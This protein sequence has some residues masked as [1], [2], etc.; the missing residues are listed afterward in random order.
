MALLWACILGII[1][2][3]IFLAIFEKEIF[4]TL[5]KVTIIGFFIADALA[6][7][8]QVLITFNLLRWKMG[9]MYDSEIMSYVS[10]I[11][12][13]LFVIVEIVSKEKFR[14]RDNLRET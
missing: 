13:T 2:S 4:F 1:L 11:T 10:A 6:M 5:F 9:P 8:V 3:L 14:R 12:V 7:T